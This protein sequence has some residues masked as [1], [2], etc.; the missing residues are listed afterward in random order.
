MERRDTLVTYDISDPKRLRKVF[1]RMNGFGDP[2]QLSVFRCELSAIE[3]QLMVEALRG[4]IHERDDQ[5]L[6]VDLGPAKA[7]QRKKRIAVL[8]RSDPPPQSGPVVV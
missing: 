1:K 8:G 2:I 6:I 3:R 7:R 5:V 4:I